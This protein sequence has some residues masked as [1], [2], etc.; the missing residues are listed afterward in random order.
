WS[1]LLLFACEI[2]ISKLNSTELKTF[3]KLHIYN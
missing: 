1:I 3:A 2:C